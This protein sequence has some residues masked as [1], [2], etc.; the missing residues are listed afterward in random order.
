M[1]EWK[2]QNGRTDRQTDRRIYGRIDGWID[3]RKIDFNRANFLKTCSEKFSLT[4]S[5][6]MVTSICQFVMEWLNNNKIHLADWNMYI[7]KFISPSVVHLLLHSQIS[8]IRARIM[9]RRDKKKRVC[10]WGVAEQRKKKF[11]VLCS[12][13][14]ASTCQM[15]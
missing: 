7:F 11:F 6:T 15:L 8:T 12:S 1:T 14:E 4:D 13:A 3:G 2:W 10:R 5:R 9:R